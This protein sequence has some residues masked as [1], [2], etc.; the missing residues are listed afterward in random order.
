MRKFA[1]L[2]LFC[3][4]LL[5]FAPNGHKFYVSTTNIEYVQEANSLQI[6]SK[7]FIDDLEDVMQ[8]RYSE[9]LSLDS[10]AD[11]PGLDDLLSKYLS[12]KL[13]IKVNGAS[14]SFTYLG[15]KYDN[16]SLSFYLEIENVASLERIEV[17]NTALFELFPEQQNIIHVK[18]S[19]KR[20]SLILEKDRPTDMLKF[21]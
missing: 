10:T 5:S 16:Q 21:N 11:T 12:K 20:R 1:W 2:I 9:T 19:Q 7:I 8:Q 14:T 18:T 6:I 13:L 17:T 15:K 4:P 3:F